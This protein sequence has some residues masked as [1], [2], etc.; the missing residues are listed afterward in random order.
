MERHVKE[1]IFTVYHTEQGIELHAQCDRY[2]N[3]QILCVFASYELAQ[4]YG[5]F[6]ARRRQLNFKNALA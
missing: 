6:A 1:P 3:K 4:E 2:P 5:G